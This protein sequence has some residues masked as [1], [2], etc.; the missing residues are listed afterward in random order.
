MDLTIKLKLDIISQLDYFG[1]ELLE[2][3]GKKKFLF[4]SDQIED[5]KILHANKL[6]LSKNTEILACA[7]DDKLIRLYF[8]NSKKI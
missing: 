4:Q 1:N 3:L 5:N 2:L 7:C 6:V 8:F